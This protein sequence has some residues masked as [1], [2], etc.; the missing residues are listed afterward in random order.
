MEGAWAVHDH[1]VKT[2]THAAVSELADASPVAPPTTAAA[3]GAGVAVAE[4]TQQ[5][6]VGSSVTER[7]RGGDGAAVQ[8]KSPALLQRVGLVVVLA[9]LVCYAVVGIVAGAVY[10]WGK[11]E[12]WGLTLL[13][14]AF[15]PGMIGAAAYIVLGCVDCFKGYKHYCCCCCCSC[16][17][18]HDCSLLFPS[19]KVAAEA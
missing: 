1:L 2:M 13:I 16:C 3:S 11:R 6:G 8:R 14:C 9:L 17:H 10:K 5:Q 18:Y 15:I 4:G 12:H 19:A 7:M